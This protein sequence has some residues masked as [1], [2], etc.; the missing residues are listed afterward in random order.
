MPKITIAGVFIALAAINF[1][2]IL[3]KK[4]TVVV[5]CEIDVNVM[6]GDPVLSKNNKKVGVAGVFIALTAIN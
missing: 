6:V 4:L 3:R 2:V 1:I 5:F